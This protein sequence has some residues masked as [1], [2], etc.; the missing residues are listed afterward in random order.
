M[1]R[2]RK[3][4]STPS[5][6][7]GQHEPN[8]A[9]GDFYV[10]FAAGTCVPT[11]SP[12]AHL[13]CGSQGATPFV[14]DGEGGEFLVR[15]LGARRNR[16]DGDLSIHCGR[17]QPHGRQTAL[18]RPGDG[19]GR[20]RI[21][22]LLRQRPITPVETRCHGGPSG[23]PS[24]LT[25]GTRT[26]RGRARALTH[27]FVR[28]AVRADQTQTLTTWGGPPLPAAG[29]S[30]GPNSRSGLGV[31]AGGRT[32]PPWGLTLQPFLLESI[33]GTA[34]S[35]MKLRQPSWSQ[36][37]ITQTRFSSLGFRGRTCAPLDPCSLSLLSAPL[38][39]K[40]FQEAVEVGRL[41]GES[42]TLTPL[43]PRCAYSSQ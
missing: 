13:R 5:R 14:P 38:V 3:R 26:G 39:E 42:N 12:E 4:R 29:A 41:K 25:G 43:F 31:V 6:N 37:K 11:T 28:R 16:G 36:S 9:I 30:T 7:S 40:A 32:P 23:G 18:S 27:R 1:A 21:L 15:N 24:A 19:R 33:A 10:Q 2:T 34:G 20:R 22:L 17:P 35:E 8:K